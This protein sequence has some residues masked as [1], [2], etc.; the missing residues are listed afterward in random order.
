MQS[1][2][3]GQEDER[4]RKRLK[5]EKDQK[6]Q[7]DDERV[8][9]A[10]DRAKAEAGKLYQEKKK[11]DRNN[12]VDQIM[13]NLNDLE[14]S[15]TKNRN[16]ED[17]LNEINKCRKEIE[18]LS[19]QQPVENQDLILEIKE[20]LKQLFHFEPEKD[21]QRKEQLMCLTLLG[22]ARSQLGAFSKELHEELDNLLDLQEEEEKKRVNEM[23]R[24][25]PKEEQEE[26]TLPPAKK[27][28]AELPK[29]YLETASRTTAEKMFQA[30]S[31]IVQLM[32]YSTP[33][34][35]QEHYEK[36]YQLA[37]NLPEL[38]T[39][40]TE[41]N[42]VFSEKNQIPKNNHDDLSPPP[43]TPSRAI[44]GWQ[45][46]L[47]ELERDEEKTA[48]PELVQ[49][50]KVNLLKEGNNLLSAIEKQLQ[51]HHDLALKG[52]SK[53]TFPKEILKKIDNAMPET[54]L[55][56][57]DLETLKKY[58]DD[59][60]SILLPLQQKNAEIAAFNK[61]IM[62]I[63]LL[64]QQLTIDSPLEE[65][66]THYTR[67]ITCLKEISRAVT[68]SKLDDLIAELA[69]TLREKRKEETLL[70]LDTPL[71]K[72]NS[73]SK[74]ETMQRLC[75]E[76]LKT[77]EKLTA[78]LHILMKGAEEEKYHTPTSSDLEE[79]DDRLY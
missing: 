7:N 34:E 79:L 77:I 19:K 44:E 46:K 49:Q 47:R 8:T 26:K 48:S 50:K 15:F 74:E 32:P 1:G 66:L 76:R 35:I 11:S 4:V 28:K 72:S 33:K 24:W 25:R 31:L 43:S 75:S 64:I 67:I 45:K 12:A 62:T 5:R 60:K 70:V 18:D 78:D 29:M 57:L 20:L 68:F 38:E 13:S 40:I 6:D 30:G 56:S 65:T 37:E 36:L 10:F 14:D 54:D 52:Q 51:I 2:E 16:V 61:R 41:L 69:V 3:L 27:Q 21:I 39:W 71:V 17:T 22:D 9:K 53:I 23:E 55:L 59:L 58:V 73:E 42:A 63:G